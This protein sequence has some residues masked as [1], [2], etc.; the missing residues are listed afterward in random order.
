MLVVCESECPEFRFFVFS[1]SLSFKV[2][3]G[4]RCSWVGVMVQN[5]EN[6]DPN[7]RGASRTN[8]KDPR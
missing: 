6:L 4:V 8:R 2:D 3:S 7:I 5:L 1:A